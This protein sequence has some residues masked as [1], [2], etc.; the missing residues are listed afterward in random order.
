MKKMIYTKL[1]EMTLATKKLNDETNLATKKLNDE[2]K[3]EISKVSTLVREEVN[4]V[5]HEM[6]AQFAEIKSLI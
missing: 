4:L 2:T 3:G 5:R 1:D 6:N